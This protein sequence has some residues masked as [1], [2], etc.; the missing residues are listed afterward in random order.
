M[1]LEYQRYGRNKGTL[2]NKTYIDSGE[3]R[4]KF[5]NAT[6]NPELNKA[7]YDAAKTALKHRSGTELE[8]M[9]W[10]D[11]KTGEIIFSITDSTVK[12]S[13]KYTRVV[14]EAIMGK[15]NIVTLHT[16]PGSM[17]PSVEDLNSCCRNGYEKGFVACHNG[18]VFGY[19]SSEMLTH[20]IYALTILKFEKRGFS[21]YDAQFATLIKLTENYQIDFWEV[22][23]NG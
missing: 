3:Y 19:S 15:T 11:G 20:N 10:F 12:H 13:I 21:E 5:D 1:A 7:L 17:P 4:R 8:D 23:S 14:N 2:V 16:H 9:Y 22:T 18:K 6:D